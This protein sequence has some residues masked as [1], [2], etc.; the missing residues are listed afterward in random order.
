MDQNW[1]CAAGRVVLV[2][3]IGFAIASSQAAE[4]A[5]Q[6]AKAPELRQMGNLPCAWQI[7]N[8]PRVRQIGNLPDVRP[9]GSLPRSEMSHI[10]DN[11]LYLASVAP[12]GGSTPLRSGNNSAP[13][14]DPASP[15]PESS[16]H[17]PAANRG[18]SAV[19]QGMPVFD[20]IMNEALKARGI[21]GGALAIAKDGKLLVARGY[22]TANL[23]TR[24]P[25]TLET[26]FSIASIS[27]T[28]TATAVLHL[29]DRRKLSLDDP[30]FSLLGKPHPLG[31]P[32]IDPRVEK[33]TVRQLLLHAGGWNPK[34]H[35]DVLRQTQ[36][37]A[38]AAA[39]KLPVSANA[40]LRYGLSQPLDFAPGAESHFSNFGDF[41]AKLA[42][43]TTA[44]QPYESY[45]RQEV[46]RPMGISDVRM[47]MLAPAYAAREAHRYGSGGRELPGGRGPI[48]APAGNWLASVV[49]LARFLTA[50][51][52]TRG[53]PFLTL[54][55]R[56]QMLAVP[57]PPLSLRRNGSHVGLGW[58]SVVEEP[59]GTEFHKSGV[60]AGVRTLIEH[61]PNGIDWVLLLNA[62]GDVPGQPSA[63][64]EIGEKIRQAIDVTRDWP[65]RDL[66]EGPTAAPAQ[67]QKSAGSVVL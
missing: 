62:D 64:S 45:V 55:A 37:I 25:V 7:G 63:E 10:A 38:R 24:E 27:K 51:S 19:G 13:K 42:I 36:K 60:A 15:L 1:I 32:T 49:D 14:P 53:K 47:E 18:S 2:A 56:Q 5:V 39:E 58:D 3:V 44:R 16:K 40:V 31:R 67:R 33:I 26:L 29:V 41:L 57:P 43:E 17:A 23:Q 12:R 50:V 35:S 59:W 20:E 61:R 6:F 46:F 11:R 9:I 4:D 34:Y 30:V 48:A 54:A 52:G 21:P 8:L 65:E 22:G 28:I 66:F